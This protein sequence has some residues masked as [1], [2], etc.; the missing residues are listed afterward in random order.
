MTAVNWNDFFQR[1]LVRLHASLPYLSLNFYALLFEIFFL[2]NSWLTKTLKLMNG[3]GEKMCS[4]SMSQNKCNDFL[5]ISLIVWHNWITKCTQLCVTLHD[6][7]FT[8]DHVTH[9]HQERINWINGDRTNE[10][11]KQTSGGQSERARGGCEQMPGCSSL[12][13]HRHINRETY[14]YSTYT[15]RHDGW[16]V[17]RK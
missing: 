9:H 10:R 15:H 12:S 5:M 17:K 2:L 1:I 16:S 8:H 13:R 6:F 4:A 14:V 3:H 11:N 7:I